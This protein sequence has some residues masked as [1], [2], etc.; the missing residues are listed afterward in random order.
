MKT[1]FAIALCAGTVATAAPVFTASNSSPFALDNT[2]LGTRDANGD[3]VN[4]GTALFGTG[5]ALSINTS[6][7]IGGSDA[8]VD[9]LGSPGTVSSTDVDNGNGTRTLTITWVLDNFA[10]MIPPGTTVGGT[11]ITTISFEAGSAN[12]AG[13]DIAPTGYAGLP[14]DGAFDLL[15]AG[16]AVLFSGTWFLT[17]N[18]TGFSGATFVSA[19]GADL[20]AFGIAGGVATITYNV[21]APA[22]AAVLG[23]GG[24]VAV[25]RRR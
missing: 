20:S 21:P 12:F 13:D 8:V 17:D 16:G 2:H 15:G 4:T 9:G 6:H 10:N 24:L 14:G 1:A 7:T 5:G 22:G 3:T 23:L 18:G 25:R 19:G 11:P